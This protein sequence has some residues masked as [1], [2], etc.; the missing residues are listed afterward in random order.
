MGM[1]Q[2]KNFV[3][4]RSRLKNWL[5]AFVR[6]AYRPEDWQ[7]EIEIF[8]QDGGSKAHKVLEAWNIAG[9][10]CF[11]GDYLARDRRLPPIEPGDIVV[12]RDAGAYTIG[13]WSK[14]NSRRCPAVVGYESDPVRLTLIKEPESIEQVLKFWGAPADR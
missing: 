11:S 14:F 4:F 2:L 3:S 13:M 8:D 9:P 12:V 5:L 7:H 1:M 6:T 10:L